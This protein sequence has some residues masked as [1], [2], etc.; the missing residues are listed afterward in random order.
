MG[1]TPLEGIIMST[2]SGDLDPSIIFHLYR[3]KGLSID[4]IDKILNQESGLLGL[5]GI[6][7]DFQKVEEAANQQ[8]SNAI[9]AIH[10][11]CY[12]IRKYIGAYLAALGGLDV[13]IFTGGIGEGSAWVR[14]LSCQDLHYMGIDLDEIKN[15]AALLRQENVIDI[16][17]EKSGANILVI[18][19]DEQRM[20]ARETIGALDKQDVTNIINTKQE[21][22]IPIEVSAHHI[23]LSRQN[24]EALFGPK[25]GSTIWTEI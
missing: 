6:S 3:E 14:A 24:V 20:I 17:S 23:H 18:P 13:L 4:E 25:Y 7:S 21:N 1:F 16:A 8:E 9:L 12:R 2:R 10:T 11:F 5:S 15:R 19:T 22:G